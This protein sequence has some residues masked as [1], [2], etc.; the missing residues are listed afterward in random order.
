VSPLDILGTLVAVFVPVFVATDPVGAL[1]LV[2]VWTG[3]LS[4][5]ER[6]RQLRPARHRARD[7]VHGAASHFRVPLVGLANP[8][9]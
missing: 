2:V 7:S 6:E 5:G 8:V 9:P 4:Q 3:A 1:P